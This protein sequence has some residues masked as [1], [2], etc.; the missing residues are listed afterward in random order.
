[1]SDDD[2]RTNAYIGW[3]A[4]DSF[5]DTLISSTQIAMETG[6][7]LDGSLGEYGIIFVVTRRAPDEPERR[8]DSGTC[9]AVWTVL[10]DLA[11]L[12]SAE[13]LIPDILRPRG[14]ER[15][16][17]VEVHGRRYHLHLRAIVGGEPPTAHITLTTNVGGPV[18]EFIR[19]AD[20]A[21]APC[22]TSGPAS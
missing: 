9:D 15:P 20:A 5:G 14:S 16:G 12:K 4:W 22:L 21:L 2:A 19:R 3:E 8:T 13:F 17:D 7:Q 18:A 10:Q 1:M 6:E 11:S